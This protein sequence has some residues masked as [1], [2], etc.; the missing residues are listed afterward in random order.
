MRRASCP[1]GVL[2]LVALAPPSLAAGPLTDLHGDPLPEGAVARFGTLRFRTRQAVVTVA[3]SADGASILSADYEATICA[4]DATTG[5]KLRSFPAQ[6]PRPGYLASLVLSAIS[7]DGRRL[8][9]GIWGDAVIRLFDSSTGR[10][11]CSL[12]GHEGGLTA[13]AF[14]ADGDC[15]ASSASDRT[16]R[17]W[18]PATGKE[19]RR[20][21]PLPRPA[22]FLALAGSGRALAY[23][24][25]DPRNFML[26]GADPEVQLLD[27]AA[28]KPARALQGFGG[29]VR[30]LAFSPD[31]KSLAAAAEAPAVR[32]WDAATGEERWQHKGAR[33]GGTGLAF[34]PDGKVLAL[35]GW[36]EPIRLYGAADGKESCQIAAH[37]GRTTAIA[38]APDGKTLATGSDCVG[39]WDIATGRDL[40]PA[41][42]HFAEVTAV[43]LSPDERTLASGGIDG[44][45]RIWEAPTGR[46][47]RRW[48]AGDSVCRTAFS[49]DGRVLAS[50][51]YS[52]NVRLWDPLSGKELRRLTGHIGTV[53]AL[54]YSPDGRVLASGGADAVLRL[55]T[56]DGAELRQLRGHD[57][58]LT[59]AAFSPDG[60]LVAVGSH[61]K[62]ASL[63]EAA[64]GRLL[65]RLTGHEDYVN[66][67]AFS[68]DGRTLATGSDD[69]T[70]RL[71]ETATGQPRGRLTG[72][73]RAVVALA[74]LPNGRTVL[75][76][77]K[78]GTLRLWDPATGKERHQFHQEW[79][80]PRAVARSRDG[81]RLFAGNTDRTILA[82]DLSPWAPAGKVAGARLSAPEVEV[83][84]ADL[85]SPDAAKAYA[86]IN[87]LAAAPKDVLP[88]LRDMI[89]TPDAAQTRRLVSDL[90]DDDYKVRERATAELE[91][92]G[93]LAE[94]EL[95]EALGG[96]PSAELRQR[97][98]FLLDKLSGAGIAPARLRQMRALEVLERMDLPEARELLRLLAKGPSDAWQTREAKAALKRAD[99]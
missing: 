91:R 19:L 30:A 80:W 51:D 20:I 1:I 97:A 61:D 15:L 36:A 71:W 46:P 58:N 72:H 85:D 31:G 49:P 66:C 7:P 87:A 4:W 24:A 25:G 54:A 28:G 64:T 27:L 60:A 55:R 92:L 50:S 37:Q 56:P 81:R 29:P 69:N 33:P 90:D 84:W 12:T 22:V 13:L 76:A 2:M 63:W 8:A 68:P 77:G 57:G 11:L 10:E 98:Q 3:Y 35:G 32:V 16:V 99:P 43:A 79:G 82:W 44:T 6:R 70:V 14:S 75:S 53:A 62:T 73:E 94:P 26:Y 42:G 47:A 41:K 5:K 89:T 39:V 45:L 59:S 78:D 52:G 83:L 95:R 67:V 86:A 65:F 48:A 17:L 38:F 23:A 40:R 34:S 9:T 88:R 18:D 93:K 74:F 21:G 96:A